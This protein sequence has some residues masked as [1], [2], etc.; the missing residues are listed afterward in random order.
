MPL[1]FHPHH[2]PAPW[3]RIGVMS[4]LVLNQSPAA[5]S[6]AAL[7]E[8][9]AAKRQ[10]KV[11]SAGSDLQRA[12]S[13]MAEGKTEE[14]LTLLE[15]TYTS[16]PEAPLT[17]ELKA[18]AK[19]GFVSAGC[20]RAEELMAIGK[21][22]EAD[23][24]LAKL[25]ATSPNN[26]QVIDCKNR[27]A[28]P[29]RYPPALTSDHVDNVKKVEA[30]LLKANSAL[31]IGDYDLSTRLYQDV[32]RIDKY[33]NAARR[34]MERVEQLK[35]RY[36]NSARDQNRAR[37]LGKVDQ[38]WEDAVPP[39]SGDLNALFGARESATASSLQGRDSIVEKLRTYRLPSIEFQGAT[40]PE[41]IELLRLRSR[42]LDPEGRGID[43]VLNLPDEL[44]SAQI[45]LSLKDIPMEEVLRY[46]TEMAGVAYRIETR[47]VVLTSLGEKNGAMITRSYRV[48]PDF[49]QNSAT[50]AA[51]AAPAADPFAA[52]AAATPAGG[53]SIKRM[54]AKE[55]L[56]SRGVQFPEG[57][58]ASFSAGTSTLVVR[59]TVP[60]MEMVEGLVEQ[61]MKTAPKLV[62]VTVRMLEVAQKNLDEL[63]F[64]WLLGGGGSNPKVDFGG[65]SFGSTNR[66][67]D[68]TQFPFS[69]VT[70]VPAAT[71]FLSPTSTTTAV[72]TNP[73]TAG[74]RS[75]SS[76]ANINRLDQLLNT[77]STAT[78]GANPAPGI[79]SIAGV[80]TDPQ[81][82]GVLRGL[83]QKKGID[84][85]ATP[86]VTT[87]NGQKATVELQREV[88]YPTEFDP[89]QVPQAG[90]GGQAAGFN[91][92]TQ[93]LATPATP[94]AFEMRKTGVILE[95]EPVIGDDGSVELNLA[96]EITD[97]EGFVNYGS[98]IIR[99]GGLNP[100]NVPVA[101]GVINGVVVLVTQL[102]GITATPDSV[103]TQNAI[104][105]PVFKTSKTNTSVRVWDGS[106]IMLSGLK[107]QDINLV[108]DKVPIIGDLPFVGKLFRSNTKQV[109]TNN[110][111][112]FVTVDIIDPSGQK[113][114]KSLPSVSSAP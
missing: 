8:R 109:E 61:S 112:F 41:V 104:L 19:A 101:I 36:L 98:P 87:K 93:Q 24:L 72:G 35:S 16:L 90:N 64:D 23:E 48:P 53:L 4:L 27:L 57:S 69:T 6:V 54:G 14:A 44:K 78:L 103:I 62:T 33:N 32:L 10:M 55:F 108:D 52:N 56:E 13:L 77:G 82:Q 85:Q 88:I 106:T 73:V 12:S 80:L 105:Q 91:F 89:P 95:V 15:A 49:I 26:K 86:S 51:A 67:A 113:V 74:L 5:D 96:P 81:F 40:V 107:R 18:A 11:D 110:V 100:I 28:D 21:R 30:L 92:P 99:T 9:E 3:F 22:P 17:H 111:I 60:N 102:V 46:V 66:T 43:F 94:T 79:L 58:S 38:L 25:L 97:F 68:L 63:G 2:T 29:D 59:N 34:G 37:L 50:S 31:E 65:G 45:S 20:I 47:A 83:S 71:A 114:R 1:K 84:I 39:S 7:A 76:A 70:T 42:D 75:G